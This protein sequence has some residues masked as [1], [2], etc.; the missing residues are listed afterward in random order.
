MT[1]SDQIKE[2][3]GKSG[4]QSTDIKVLAFKSTS[5]AELKMYSRLGQFDKAVQQVQPM[6]EELDAYS[7]KINKEQEILFYYNVAYVFFG[8]GEFNKSLFWINKVLNDNESS[9]RQ[10]IY[11]YARLFNLVIHFELGN[12]DLLEYI[13]KSTSRYLTKRQR[14]FEVENLIMSGIK[15]L[16]K[17]YDDEQKDKIYSSLKKDL[18]GVLKK[19]SE[20]IILEYFDFNTWLESK[21][22]KRT[23]AEE[24]K[25]SL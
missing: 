17:A 24:I 19:E 5:L 16:A 11:S 25:A 3:I 12:H 21:I 10:D 8:D 13:I 15:K 23:F 1:H 4:F 18:K 2:V 6:I 7:D 9:L 22:N 20:K 14:A